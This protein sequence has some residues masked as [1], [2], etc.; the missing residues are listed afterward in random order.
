M[1]KDLKSVSTRTEYCAIRFALWLGLT[2]PEAVSE[3]ILGRLLDQA[4]NT[5]HEIN[6]MLIS[7]QVELEDFGAKLKAYLPKD[8]VGDHKENACVENN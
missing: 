7:Q 3:W 6:E 4:A 5:V 2:T 8:R 1:N